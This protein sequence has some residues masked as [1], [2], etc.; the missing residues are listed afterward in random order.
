ME[1]SGVQENCYNSIMSCD[2][3]IRKDLY[4]NIVLSGGTTM[5]PGITDRMKKEIGL[6]APRFV[7]KVLL[8]GLH[9]SANGLLER[10][11]S[12]LEYYGF[13]STNYKH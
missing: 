9:S 4:S 12:L 7:L 1:S 8:K 3:D 10:F 13:C 2:I 6:L 5:Y 11:F